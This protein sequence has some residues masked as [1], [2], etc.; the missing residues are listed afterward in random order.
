MFSIDW[1]G[2]VEAC[3]QGKISGVS[4]VFLILDVFICM[5]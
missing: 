2:G 1:E 4:F 3:L 5:N